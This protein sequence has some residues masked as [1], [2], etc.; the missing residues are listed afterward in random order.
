MDLAKFKEEME[1]EIASLHTA[2]SELRALLPDLDIDKLCGVRSR[3]ARM[4]G[5]HEPALPD[6]LGRNT[7]PKR[8]STFRWSS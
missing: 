5:F 6:V 4:N 3:F 2:V 8:T 1:R 7:T